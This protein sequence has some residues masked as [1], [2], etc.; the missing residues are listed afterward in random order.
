MTSTTPTTIASVADVLDRL[1]GRRGA[2]DVR[3]YRGQSDCNWGLTAAVFRRRSHLEAELDILKKFRQNAMQRLQRLPSSDWEWLFLA[4]HHGLPTRLL[5]WSENPLVALYFAVQNIESDGAFFELNPRALN[6]YA[7]TGAP[8]VVMFDHDPLLN[9]YLPTEGPKLAGH[10][11]AAIAGR[12]FD[13]IVAQT[14]TFT[15][16]K[17]GS[18]LL[19]LQ[20]GAFV[21]QMT[22]PRAAK[23]SITAELSDL[24]INEGTVYPDLAHIGNFLKEQYG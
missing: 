24:N 11:V 1:T 10:P 16:S 15:V 23:S 7:A 4:Q 14:G 12:S 8:R 22:I 21:E 20:G 6:D 9:D 18:D 3:W 5:D 2:G 19:Q 13:R 17:A